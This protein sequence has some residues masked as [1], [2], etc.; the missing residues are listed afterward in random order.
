MGISENPAVAVILVNWNGFRDTKECLNS[1]FRLKYAA[2]QV[3]VVDNG[4]A[5]VYSNDNGKLC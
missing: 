4:S 5:H 1:L 3:V 2:F